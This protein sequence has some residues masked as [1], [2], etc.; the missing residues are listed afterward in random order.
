M[1]IKCTSCGKQAKI[2][3]SQEG[4][5]VKCPGCGHVY[6]ARSAAA[7]AGG[8]SSRKD[9]PT[10]Y[11]IIG[12]VVVGALI[13]ALF[14]MRGADEPV[15]ANDAR[16][17]EEASE[18]EV[19]KVDRTGWDGAVAKF[20]RGLHSMAAS[21][22]ASGLR[23]KLDAKAAYEYELENPI[24]VPGVR[25]DEAAEGAT[26]APE[27][28]APWSELTESERSRFAANF[29]ERI[30]TRGVDGDFASWKPYDMEPVEFSG[31]L[32][33]I[34]LRN[35]WTGD[36]EEAK[37]RWTEIVARQISPSDPSGWKL[38]DARRYYTEEEVA[39]L[40]RG[41]RKERPVKR[42]LSDGSTVYEAE[43]VAVEFDPAVAPEKRERIRGLVNDFVEDVNLRPKARR[44]IQ[45][46]L[47]A[48]G[49][50]V[51]PALLTRFSE[52]NA[53][54]A[55][56]EEDSHY[57]RIRMKM[58]HDLLVE[59]TGEEKNTF[60]ISEAMGGTKERIASGVKQWFAW[61]ERKFDR[62]EMPEDEETIDPLLDDPD[63]K[64]LNERERRLLQEERKKR[65]Q[66]KSGDG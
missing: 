17:G 30:T 34:R 24:V 36:D 1:L 52:L 32:A 13:I 29:A 53:G 61:Y 65:D 57:D 51:I 62:F 50:Q 54:L 18:T 19:E 63:F 3:D 39:A 43:A 35:K 14:A 47:V 22:N 7:R 4:A 21:G 60:E 16:D 26:E 56:S 9:D 31:E 33:T 2:P 27:E 12:G 5:K 41:P 10:K 44:E 58:I 37:D 28:R 49:K 66:K 48:E 64:P 6:V 59:I 23:T 38:V 55:A 25:A 15:R 8:G 20:A 40:N 46:A 45:D 42:E 11:F